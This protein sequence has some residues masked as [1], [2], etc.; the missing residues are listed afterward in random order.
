MGDALLCSARCDLRNVRL[1]PL[2]IDHPLGMTITAQRWHRHSTRR[3][4]TNAPQEPARQFENKTAIV[5]MS[6]LA[7]DA[8]FA[9]SS[10]RTRRTGI[11]RRRRDRRREH[12]TRRPRLTA[13]EADGLGLMRAS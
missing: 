12:I 4:R 8:D 13:F 5:T 2:R 1:R 10:S 7:V 11:T 9:L 6:E 3:Q